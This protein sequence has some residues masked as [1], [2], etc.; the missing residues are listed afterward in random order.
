MKLQHP[1]TK[2]TFEVPEEHGKML[3]ERGFYKEYVAPK[4]KTSAPKSKE[5]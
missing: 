4:R 1:E 2:K 5:D 3:L